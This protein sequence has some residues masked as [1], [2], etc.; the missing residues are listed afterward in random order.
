MNEEFRN[1]EDFD[2]YEIS[3]LGNVR[4]KKTNKILKQSICDGYYKIN[5]SKN[6]TIKNKKIHKLVAN[7]FIENPENKSCVDHIDNNRLNNN[8]S[9]LRYATNKENQQN[10]KLSS[11]NT[12]GIKG[13]TYENNKWRARINI[14]GIKI[15][16]GYFENIEDAK[17]ARLIKAQQ[18]FGVYMNSCE[19]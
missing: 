11:K 16:L 1:I 8:I 12:S 14:D 15:H 7:A 3:N 10:S 17:Q 5:L 6:G 4:N 9:N 2:N 13:V 18:V 19:N